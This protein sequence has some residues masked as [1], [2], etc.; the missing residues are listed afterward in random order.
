MH[1]AR[2]IGL[3]HAGLA[4]FAVALLA[5]AAHVQ[6]WERGRWAARAARQQIAVRP[7]PAP[8]GEIL[9]AAGAVLA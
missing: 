7:V 6:L 3:V 9:D 5:K 2:R 8:R 4:L 1:R